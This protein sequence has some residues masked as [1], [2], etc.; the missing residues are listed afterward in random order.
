MSVHIQRALTIL[1]QD[2]LAQSSRVEE[3]IRIACR[4]LSRGEAERS[5]RLAELEP[6]INAREVLIE[7]EC[8]QIL[9]LNQPVAV[10]LRRV[11]TVL[12][13]NA[14]LERIAD[15][16]VNIAE[17]ARSLGEHPGFAIPQTL[18]TMAETAIDM[19]RDALDSFCTLDA[20]AARAVCRRD[21]DVDSFNRAV[22]AQLIEV[23]RNRSDL[24]EPALHFFS[25]ARHIER[26]ADHATNIAEDVIYLVKGEIARHR[27]VAA[28]R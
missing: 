5:H 12:K 6:E 21:D 2:I 1:E 13:I 23:M 7:E 22:I 19:V 3:V 20:E 18:E 15:L 27:R 11:T 8:L 14:D 16:G 10:D 9:A 28:E 25:A 24:I 4:A 26:I 17:R